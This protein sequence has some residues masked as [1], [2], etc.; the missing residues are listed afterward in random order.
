MVV[1]LYHYDC[2]DCLEAIPLYDQMG[3]DLSDNNN[4]IRIAF[5]EVPP[6]GP[7]AASPIPPETLCLE[8]KLDPSKK[9]YLTTPLV[10]VIEN[11]SVI[12]SWE[13]EVPTLDE[14]LEA[15]FIGSQD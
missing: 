8:G 13:V 3:R 2:P 6:Y 10:V 15:V 14:I 7:L 9:W 11:G 1:L 12:K 5:I 4:A